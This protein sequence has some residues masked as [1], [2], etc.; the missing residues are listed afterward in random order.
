MKKILIIKADTNDAD[1]VEKSTEIAEEVIPLIK[2]VAKAIKSC[3]AN[4]NWGSG[5]CCDE[6]ESPSI[7]YKDIL[8]EEEIDNFDYYVPHG[9]YG[10]H[11]IE[12]I[13]IVTITKEEILL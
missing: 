13:R 1:Y 2:K 9:E 3:K 6:D 11:T 5:E 12:S 7:V 8:T 10:I 4:Y